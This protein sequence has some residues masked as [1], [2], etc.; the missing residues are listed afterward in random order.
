[1]NT[2]PRTLASLS[3]AVLA[4]GS[5]PATAA[6]LEAVDAEGVIAVGDGP[7]TPRALGED[8]AVPD[9]ISSRRAVAEEADTGERFET[10]CGFADGRFGCTDIGSTHGFRIEAAGYGLV[11][12]YDVAGLL[13]DAGITCIT[14]PDTD[15][16]ASK[17][18]WKTMSC[19]LE[20]DDF[21]ECSD[22]CDEYGYPGSTTDATWV[23]G[24]CVLLCTCYN[25]DGVKMGTVV[26]PDDL[27]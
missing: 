23:D 10:T 25:S 4:M 24:A 27:Y 26:E 3:L 1:M 18:N 5:L 20:L 6:T 16:R 15:I 12:A 11:T 21:A 19:E 2:I 17:W 9:T 8:I 13:E 14:F 22:R 7:V